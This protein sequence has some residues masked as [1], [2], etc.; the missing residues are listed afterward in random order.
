MSFAEIVVHRHVLATGQ[1][2]ETFEWVGAHD[3]VVRIRE[4]DLV[5][6]IGLSRL[7]WQLKEVQYVTYQGV[8]YYV[9]EDSGLDGWVVERR[10]RLVRWEQWFRVRVVA[11]LAIWG[12]ARWAESTEPRW[13]D[14]GRKGR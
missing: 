10:Y 6:R 5:G 14:I 11:T 13:S 8:A 4:W 3:G 2:Y 7:P 1:H 9:R 12:L